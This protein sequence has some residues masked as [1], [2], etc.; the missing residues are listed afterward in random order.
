MTSM[1]LTNWVFSQ[2]NNQMIYG[3]R[4]GCSS[5]RTS[6]ISGNDSTEREI[7]T[8]WGPGSRVVFAYATNRW[9]FLHQSIYMVHTQKKMAKN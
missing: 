4:P 1:I 7:M 5:A 8:L 2:S 9:I 6:P 3:D